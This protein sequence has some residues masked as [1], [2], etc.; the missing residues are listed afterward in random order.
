MSPQRRG[1]ATLEN[2]GTGLMKLTSRAN[3]FHWGEFLLTLHGQ[4]AQVRLH[5]LQQ[6]LHR[7]GTAGRHLWRCLRQKRINLGG[8]NF[9]KRL[10]NAGAHYSPPTHSQQGGYNPQIV[11]SAP[12]ERKIKTPRSIDTGS[13]FSASRVG[14]E[15]SS[16]VTGRRCSSSQPADISFAEQQP[17]HVCV[18]PKAAH[19]SKIFAK[20][21]S[22]PSAADSSASLPTMHWW[23]VTRHSDF[24]KQWPSQDGHHSDPCWKRHHTDV[25]Y[26]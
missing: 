3:L 9:K 17:S 2:Q 18:P 19:S 21:C 26:M 16:D 23:T 10:R 15:R 5:V 25:W 22:L 8:R 7:F 14:A 12:M 4:G 24:R 1:P 6:F 11:H 20:L 13:H